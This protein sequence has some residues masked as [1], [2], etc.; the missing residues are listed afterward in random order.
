MRNEKFKMERSEIF[1]FDE[2]VASYFKFSIFEAAGRNLQL[3]IYYVF[4]K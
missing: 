1:S 2:I 3:K 4:I